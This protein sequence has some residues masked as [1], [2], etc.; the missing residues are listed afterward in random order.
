[1]W[2]W[3]NYPALSD[4]KAP[5]RCHFQNFKLPPKKFSQ[6]SCLQEI[7]FSFKNLYW[8]FG[9]LKVN[10][11]NT[12]LSFHLCVGAF[13][14]WRFLFGWTQ[15]AEALELIYVHTTWTVRFAVNLLF[16][17]FLLSFHFFYMIYRTCAIITRSWLVT[18][19]MYKPRILGL[20]NE[21][22][23]FLVHKLSEI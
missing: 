20:K 12:Y 8:E 2:Q 15:K 13:H 22:F 11:R 9:I 5:L 21:E 1:M 6:I 18:A 4:F 3:K 14:K 19:L 10:I 16:F 7:I 23:W 17:S